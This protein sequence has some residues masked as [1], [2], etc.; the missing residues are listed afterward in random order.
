MRKYDLIVIGGVA[1]GTKAAAKARRERP[2]WTIA[3]ITADKDVSYAGCGL[4]YLIGGVVKDRGQLV[5]RTPELLKRNH[6]IDVMTRHEALSIDRAGHSVLV[7]D[8]G[9]GEEFRL[10]YNRLFLA[11]GRR[12][13]GRQSRGLIQNACTRC[14]PWLTRT[15]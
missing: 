13:S 14:A 3:L 9:T 7:R 15:L 10:E 11:T 8:L 12:P 4:P 6:G 1:A 2:G 5:A